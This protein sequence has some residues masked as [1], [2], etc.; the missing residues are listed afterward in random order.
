M[1]VGTGPAPAAEVR[2]LGAVRKNLF[3]AGKWRAA[4]GGARIAVTNPA[5][6]QLPAVA[7]LDYSD[8]TRLLFDQRLNR[9]PCPRRCSTS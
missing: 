7:P 4:K 9:F 2:A 8:N 6:S 3:I 1:T 5:T